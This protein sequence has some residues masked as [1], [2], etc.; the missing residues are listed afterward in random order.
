MPFF[1]I[2]CFLHRPDFFEGNHGEHPLQHENECAQSYCDPAD[3]EFGWAS[4]NRLK[5]LDEFTEER[6]GFLDVQ[7]VVLEY[8]NRASIAVFPHSKQEYLPALLVSCRVYT[9]ISLH[10]AELQEEADNRLHR[11]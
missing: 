7:L 11:C 1:R 5:H 3:V 2:A 6:V 9:Q 8:A 10:R 4:C